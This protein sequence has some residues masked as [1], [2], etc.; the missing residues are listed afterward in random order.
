MFK[1]RRVKA[2]TSIVVLVLFAWMMA[3]G[4]VWAESRAAQRDPAKALLRLMDDPRLALSAEE[5]GY[6]R[7]AAQRMES[8]PPK[9][10]V[11]VPAVRVGSDPVADL[12]QIA[13]DLSGLAPK[14]AVSGTTDE[15]RA[16]EASGVT[17]VT[18]RL[19][20]VHERVLKDFAD[21]EGRLRAAGL[22]QAILARHEAAR[23]EYVKTIQTV[24]Q[25]LDVA[26]HAQDPAKAE[27]AL[28]SAARLL[29]RST[30]ERPHQKLDL[31]RL[32]FRA[33]KP[34]T[35]KP[36][37]IPGGQPAKAALT[38]KAFT[39]PTPADLAETEDVQITP[40][41][42]AL[43]ASLGNQPLKIFDWV[44]DNV[45]FVPTYGSVQGSEMTLVAKRGNAFDTASLL[46]AL[47]RAAGVPARYVTGTVEVPAASALN[48]VGG[49]ETSNVAQQILGQGGVP[50]VALVSGGTVT[51]L[52]I[53]HVWVEAFVNYVPSRG[54]T[55][56]QGNTW[57]P[58][59]PAFK[60]HTF[61]PRSALYT[62]NPIGDVLQL[63]D[64][65]F[66]SD[67]SLGKISNVDT[68][69]LHQRLGD[70]SVRTA[71]YIAA[72]GGPASLP[73]VTGGQKVLAATSTVFAGSLPYRV[74]TR[75]A[76]LSS[77]P[78]SLRHS[79]TLNG[80]ASDFDRALGSPA[81]SVKLSLPALNS[82]RLGIEFDP[83][84]QADADTLAA[85]RSGG[86]SS[87]PVYL[88]HVVPVVKVDGVERGRGTGVVMGSSYSIDVVLAGP[89]GPTTVPFQVVAGDEIV[90]GVTG[91]GV[92]RQVVEKR[93]ADFAV[94]NAPEYLHQIG[95]NYWMECDTLGDAAA[96][97]HGVHQLRL[98]S[99]GFFSS[100]L[101]V[102]YL[103]GS[104]RSGVYQ[105][106]S[107]DV[108]QSL[109]GI[110]GQDS[111]KV[112]EFFKQA[113]SQGS[114][115]EGATFDQ[116]K[117]S[118]SA[119]IKGISSIHLI[120]AAMSQGIPVYRVTSA[121]SGAVLPLL[122]LSSA[123]KSD[124]AT[125]LN[126]GKTVLVPE[127][128]VN[129][130]TWVGVGYI[131]QDETTGAGAY[132][133]S[134]GLAGGG[135]LDCLPDLVPVFEVILVI[136]LFLLLI[137]LIIAA[138]LSAPAWAPAAAAAGLFLLLAA[139]LGG[140]NTGPPPIA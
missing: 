81:F 60:L 48:W 20:L 37:T 132:L 112:V 66:D 138:I 102:S 32:P 118:S 16:A 67:E 83:A 26:R 1:N 137:A 119:A 5:K 19:K 73:D 69:P 121:N 25:D 85:A 109:L 61:I 50:N 14:A 28:A 34:V 89:E 9:P 106:R 134:G 105:D 47:L 114:Y 31:S 88:I 49:A 41:I 6:L 135:L 95:L 115:L 65:L 23:A 13:A 52:R 59:D 74:V 64:H 126:Q 111:A 10:R 125:A 17:G 87:L 78:A 12:Q 139:G 113:G 72:H 27:S 84:T 79:V 53:D 123:V 92:A 124:I 131:I 91:N 122:A 129:L 101:S 94:D 8:Q 55:G 29:S 38:A 22:P 108:R 99:V 110:A 107:M 45:E 51:A 75:G 120:T 128:N 140:L 46:I 33:A 2:R 86:A 58:L 15:K 100:P 40:D 136:L 80:F 71:D 76:A 104:P 3:G 68:D 97:A 18:A 96:R 133:I 43:A 90:A 116:F 24:F 36:G 42:R 63:D 117:N 103:F 82:R 4:D 35:R 98:P 130:G 77:L 70:W 127:R 54:A 62:D 21:T 7:Q 56:G 30:T 39:P 44:H 11:S 57:A 93:F